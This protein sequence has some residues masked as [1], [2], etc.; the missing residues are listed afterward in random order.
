ML[1][2]QFSGEE[3]SCNITVGDLKPRL[4]NLLLNALET[5]TDP[6]NTQMLLAGLLLSVQDSACS[7]GESVTQPDA[8]SNLFSSGT[9]ARLSNFLP[10]FRSVCAIFYDFMIFIISF[11]SVSFGV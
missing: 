8:S 10:S 4:V 3:R 7:E 5:E 9:D 6:V 11:F 2:Y 1:S